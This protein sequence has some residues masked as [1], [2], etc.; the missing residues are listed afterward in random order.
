M[1]ITTLASIHITFTGRC[2]AI[3]GLNSAFR[4]NSGLYKGKLVVAFFYLM[5]EKWSDTMHLWS[6][7]ILRST[8]ARLSL[9]IPTGYLIRD[10]TTHSIKKSSS[11]RHGWGAA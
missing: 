7:M 3:R 10:S 1:A 11:A 8:S 2:L 5:A 4:R 6:S 9:L